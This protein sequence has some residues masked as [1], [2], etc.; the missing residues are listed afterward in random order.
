M[1]NALTKL[2]KK[3]IKNLPFVVWADCITTCA[4]TRYWP[5]R[6]VFGQDC[7]LP[8]E[9]KATSCAVIAWEKVRWLVDLLVARPRQLERKEKDILTIQES[10]RRSRLQ[11]NTQFDK[12]HC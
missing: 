2:G 7:V 10:I 6:L 5:Y 3:W 8:V 1:L 11:N 4:S 12:V 9:L